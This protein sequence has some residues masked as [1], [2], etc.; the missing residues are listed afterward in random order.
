M[1]FSFLE[2]IRRSSPEVRKS[3][4]LFF[5]VGI[6]GFIILV[7][8]TSIYLTMLGKRSPEEQV[9]R[10]VPEGD[11]SI[12]ELFDEANVFTKGVQLSG[13]KSLEETW[14]K[15]KIINE[16]ASPVTATTTNALEIS[17]TKTA[18]NSAQQI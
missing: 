4:T 18:T 5:T 3:Y 11:N 13:T 15:E 2:K 1:L 17:D 12:R 9:E 6:T 14:E 10:S 16:E 8:L 7:Y